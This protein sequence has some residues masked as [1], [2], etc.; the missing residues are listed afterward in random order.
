MQTPCYYTAAAVRELDR[1]AIEEHGISGFDLMQRAGQAAFNALR[2]QWP[3]AKR[4]VLFCGTGNNGGDG[5]I[6]AALAQAAGLDVLVQVAGSRESIGGTA[7]QALEYALAQ[8]VEIHFTTDSAAPVLAAAALD[9]VVVDALLGTGLSGPVRP[10]QRQVIENINAS[11][12]PVL[13]L[14]IPSGLCSDTGA[15]LGASVQAD[16]TVTFIGRKIG[17]IKDE[18]PAHCGK[19]LFD[20]LGVPAEIYRQVEPSTIE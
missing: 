7:L 4:L 10:Q 5:F 3:E 19:V 12:L 14:D 6:V 16:L 13:S 1:L 15:V 20:D 8:D 9:T 18:G 17:L 2:W 11:G